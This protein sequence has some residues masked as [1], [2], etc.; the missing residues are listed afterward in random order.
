MYACE[1]YLYSCFLSHRGV[2]FG[3]FLAPILAVM[4]FNMFIFA[5][6]I[7]VV[8]RHSRNTA[9]LQK[10][11]ISLKSILRKI[12]SISGIMSLFGLTWIF[13]ILTFLPINELKTMFDSLFVIFNSFQGLFIFF[14][15]IVLNK[16]IRESWKELLSCGKYQSKHLPHFQPTAPKLHNSGK[17]AI[18]TG[19]KGTT[20]TESSNETDKLDNNDT[21]TVPQFESGLN[22]D[23]ET[24][25]LDKLSIKTAIS[26]KATVIMKVINETKEPSEEIAVGGES[27]AEDKD[28]VSRMRTRRYSTLKEFK[29]HVEQIELDFYDDDCDKEESTK[30]I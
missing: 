7:V 1:L 9:A 3:A 10:K 12:V 5:W 22:P 13:A 20:V 28:M 4:V 27:K 23:R 29:H 2:F 30:Q 18:P 25:E 17:N 15:Y 24:I 8:I 19:A 11:D 6:V 21:K 14:F 26:I 16:E